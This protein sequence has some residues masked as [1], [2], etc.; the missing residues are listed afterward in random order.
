[1]RT[2]ISFVIFLILSGLIYSS[3]LGFRSRKYANRAQNPPAEVFSGEA[4][5]AAQNATHRDVEQPIGC[6][7]RRACKPQPIG[8]EILRYAAGG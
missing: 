6:Q 7:G 8:N 3:D 4:L 5:S 2:V 1:M